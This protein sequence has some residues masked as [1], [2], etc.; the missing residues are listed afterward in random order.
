M[1]VKLEGLSRGGLGGV[2]IRKYRA[3]NAG[4][5]AVSRMGGMD[6]EQESHVVSW[7]TGAG[8]FLDGYRGGWAVCAEPQLPRHEYDQLSKGS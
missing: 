4:M 5:G 8:E 3:R 2:C 7:Q 1:P 6:G